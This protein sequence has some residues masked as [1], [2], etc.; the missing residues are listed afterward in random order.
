MRLF[1]AL[2]ERVS[3][4]VFMNYGVKPDII[5]MAKGL[6][7]A[8]LPLSATAVKREIYEAFSGTEEYDFFPA[9]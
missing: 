5:T 3:R 2:G 6:T 9:Y 1:A 7:S 8:Y 4:L